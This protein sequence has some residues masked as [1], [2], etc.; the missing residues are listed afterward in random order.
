MARTICFPDAVLMLV[1]SEQK[2]IRALM[3]LS[4]LTLLALLGEAGNILAQSTATLM[5]DAAAAS[6]I[7]GYRLYQGRASNNYTLTNSLGKVT[8]A[9]ISGLS[10]GNTYYFAVTSL[11]ASGLESPFSKEIAYTV[12]VAA[13]STVVL[14]ASSGTITAPFTLTNGIVSQS[15]TTSLSGSGRAAYSFNVPGTGDYL[16][17]ANVKAPGEGANSFFVNVDAEP[18]DPYM[19]WD[20]PVAAA[21]TNRTVAWRGNGTVDSSQFA[22]K[23]FNLAQG[24]HQLIIRGREAKTQLGT[25]TI[26]PATVLPAPWQ[27]LDIGNPGRTGTATLSATSGAVAGAGVIGGTGDKFRFLYQPLT[28]DGEI[29]AQLGALS[30]TNANARFGVMLRE[31]LTSGAASAFIGISPDGGL[32]SQRR[33]TTAGVMSVVTSGATGVSNQ[34]VRLARAGNVVTA[35]KSADAINWSAVDTGTMSIAA[36]IYFGFAIASGTTNAVCSGT[37]N[38]ILAVP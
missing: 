20:I 11:D 30:G 2:I 22:P 12:P 9:T 36:N 28:G 6:G 13:G 15:K 25:L 24:P 19:I 26:S 21:F 5:W 38:N 8:S 7:S 1:N 18:S 33:L 17:S 14:P 23:I 31:T 35:Y 29:R 34:W 10:P 37:F 3:A 16:L 27:A 4:N 32:R